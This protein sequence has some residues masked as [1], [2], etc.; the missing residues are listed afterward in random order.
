[1]KIDENTSKVPTV[2]GLVSTCSLFVF[3]ALY[4]YQKFNNL[5]QKEGVDILYTIKENFF[6]DESMISRDGVG[7]NFA[8]GLGAYGS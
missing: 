7:I 8:V 4:C 5:I 1:M 6:T 3:L 2:L